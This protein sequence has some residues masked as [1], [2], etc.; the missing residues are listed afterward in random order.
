MIDTLRRITPAPLRR[1]YHRLLSAAAAS[2]YGHPAQQLIVIGV[3][4][5]DGKTTTATMIADIFQAA[6]WRVGLSSSVWYQVGKRRWM[7][8]SHVTMPGR[9]ALHRLLRDMMT[10]KCRVAVIEVSSE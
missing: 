2:W 1:L 6:G 9:F 7:N 5:T 10:A 3:T 8:E 4:G